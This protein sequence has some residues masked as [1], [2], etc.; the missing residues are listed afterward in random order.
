MNEKEIKKHIEINYDYYYASNRFYYKYAKKYD[1]SD[2]ALFTLHIIYNSKECIQNTLSEKLSLP[3]QTVCSI[4]D[5]FENK[6]YIERKINPKDKRN[7]LI[8]LTYKGMEFAKPILKDLENLDKKIL[9]ILSDEDI[10][11]YTDCQKDII[12]FMENYF[13]T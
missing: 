11:K 9:K 5:N 2:M 12:K 4:L 7:R 8:S 3:K 13:K 6:G 10:K 1:M